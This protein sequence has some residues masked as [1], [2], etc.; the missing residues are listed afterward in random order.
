VVD[1]YCRDALKGRHSC[2][3]LKKAINRFKSDIK[4]INEA[5]WDYFIDWDYIQ[6]FYE[7]SRAIKLPDRNE[8]LEL[9]PWQ[10]FCIA[11]LLGWRYKNN[12]EKRRF[13][14][15]TIFVPRKN[16]KTTGFMYPLLL[17]DLMTTESSES[18]LFAKDDTQA[19]HFLNDIKKIV[20]DNKDLSRSVK[21]NVSTIQLK[22]SKISCFSSPTVGIDGY[23]PS[24]AVI[25]EYWCFKNERCVTA[26]R[27][28]G[29]ARLNSLVLIITTAGLDISLPAF[30]E[31]EK[32]RKILNGVLDD[33]SYF[34][35]IYEADE[36]DDWK[37][38]NSY[39]KANPSID[40]ILDRKVLEQD[41]Q[42]ALITPSH[43]SDYKAKT[44]NWWANDTSNW[45][46][47]QKWE[48]KKRN[49]T[50]DLSEFEGQNCYAG[51]D[52]SSIN[53]F[54]AYTKCFHKDGH[55]YLF[56]K[57]YAPSEQ[58][59]EKYKSENINIV[60]WTQKGLV[61]AIPGATIDYDFIKADI[62]KDDERFNV[63][64]LAYDRWNANKFIDSLEETIPK[65]LLIQ[66]DQSLKQMSNPTK[67]FERLIYEDKIIDPNPVMKWMVSNA[68]IKPDP[69][70]NYKPLKEYKSSTKRI[71]GVITS[72]MAI[73][74]CNA[75]E[76]NEQPVGKDFQS[77]LNLF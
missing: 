44:L 55:Y 26:M 14:T 17:W 76:G 45:I 70:N 51:L 19:F 71:D 56:H 38:S 35:I 67:Y 7:F 23:K 24:L 50:I 9:L 22:K 21:H 43:Q 41:L 75:N 63:M 49:Q 18:Y 27:Y 33:E 32:V 61:T 1:D 30:A 52:L 60:E 47:L 59:K 68:V 73:D 57:F 12:K 54:T 36:N 31:H 69:N 8:Y 65:T 74:R 5:S 53:D 58:V 77:I 40:K 29:R 13:R 28:G 62:I 64:E 6:E 25:D 15:G 20:S 72:I 37:D 42:D 39:V 4:R 3:Y 16:G 10:L 34:G 2:G 11:N 66:Y 46:P 48:T